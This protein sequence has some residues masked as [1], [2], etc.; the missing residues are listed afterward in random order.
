MYS[1]DPRIAGKKLTE[2]LSCFC[3]KTDVNL[4]HHTGAGQGKKSQQNCGFAVE[5]STDKSSLQALSAD[6]VRALIG[7]QSASHCEKIEKSGYVVI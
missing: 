5:T 3:K 2:R 7:S 1:R 6:V 4:L